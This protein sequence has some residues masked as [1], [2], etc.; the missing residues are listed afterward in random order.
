MIMFLLGIS[1]ITYKEALCSGTTPPNWQNGLDDVVR[2]FSR[3][4]RHER[5]FGVGV[6]KESSAVGRWN[7]EGRRI[8]R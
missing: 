2:G 5:I 8:L 7:D 1:R 4:P 6:S 3:K